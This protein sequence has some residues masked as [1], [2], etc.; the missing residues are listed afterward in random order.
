MSCGLCAFL[1]ASSAYA[2]LI[3][4]D[5]D[6][7]EYAKRAQQP[8]F[9]CVASL[10]VR[11]APDIYRRRGS[12]VLIAP[13]WLLTCAHVAKLD[14]EQSLADQQW[15]INGKTYYPE[16]IVLHSSFR[17]DKDA[18]VLSN[19]WD[20]GLVK[21]DKRI[22]DVAPAN[23][24]PDSD[25]VGQTMTLVGY[26]RLGDGINGP[27]SPE[28]RRLLA[29]EN[30]IDAAGAT[31][32]ILTLG[33]GTL[34]FDFDHPDDAC[35]N[36]FGDSTPLNLEAGMLN[37]DSGGG[38][39]LRKN[40][41]WYLAGLMT[42]SPPRSGDLDEPHSQRPFH[43]RYGQIGGGIRISSKIRWINDVLSSDDGSVPPRD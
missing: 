12:G 1:L 22:E 29:G 38:M 16:R 43:N 41:K 9:R 11:I 13:Q 19:G 37:G 33:E 17:V 28:V 4:H 32:G 30:V 27:Q 24:Y 31:V 26:G 2:E 8:Q 42:F 36:Y 21:L 39:F 18:E 10:Q 14:R 34:M 6:Q 40:D 20:L 3:R 35:V 25:E 15:E 7:E 5:R 23:C